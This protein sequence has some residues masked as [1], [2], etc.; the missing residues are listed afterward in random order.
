[1]RR[2]FALHS[3][4]SLAGHTGNSGPK[5]SASRRSAATPMPTSAFITPSAR[6]CDTFLLASGVPVLSV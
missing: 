5:P 1:M 4:V 3:S 2:F 6:A